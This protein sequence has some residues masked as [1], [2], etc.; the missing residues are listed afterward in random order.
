MKKIYLLAMAVCMIAG[1]LNAQKAYLRLGIGGGVGLNQYEGYMWA[2]ATSTNTSDNLVIKSM[3]LGSGFNVNPAFGYM[4]TENVGVEIGVNEFIG[5]GK[6]IHTFRTTSTT[7]RSSDTKVSGMMLQI[8]PAI[9]FTAGLKKVNPYGRLGMIVGVLPSIATTYNS[10]VTGIP[11]K[12]TSVSDF[13]EKDYGGIAIGFTTAAGIEFN[14]SE[15]F[16]FFGEFVFNGITYAP[17]KGK[18]TKNSVDGVDQLAIMTTNQ[19]QWTYEKKFDTG[20]T[21]PDGSPD[22][23]PKQSFNFSNVELNIGVKFKL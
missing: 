21:I 16:S 23:F 5:F 8:V 22:K 11:E 20:E 10:T 12:A 1:A 3:G 2:D 7:D 13:K 14:F 18:Y 15:K 4:L 6:K 19:K 17:A 9:V